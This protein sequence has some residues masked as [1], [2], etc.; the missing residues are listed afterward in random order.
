MND[1]DERELTG[2]INLFYKD[3]SNFLKERRKHI[4]SFI[5]IARKS[6]NLQFFTKWE[7]IKCKYS[8]ILEKGGSIDNFVAD[9]IYN[10]NETSLNSNVKHLPIRI[11]P[12]V[13]PNVYSERFYKLGMVKYIDGSTS[14]I[15]NYIEYFCQAIE[16]FGE[17]AG[18]TDNNTQNHIF[19]NDTKLFFD[20]FAN[21]FNNEDRIL[22]N[23]E[24]ILKNSVEY[25]TRVYFSSNYIPEWADGIHRMIENL[26]K[27]PYFVDK[28]DQ[29]MYLYKCAQYMRGNVY[30]DDALDAI[31]FCYQE[32]GNLQINNLNRLFGFKRIMYRSLSILENHNDIVLLDDFQ[33]RAIFDFLFSIRKE[34]LFVSL[35]NKLANEIDFDFEKI[36]HYYSICIKESDLNHAKIFWRIMKKADTHQLKAQYSTT[37]MSIVS[38]S[39]N[40]KIRDNLSI[41]DETTS[42]IEKICSVV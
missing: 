2:L 31:N 23:G 16:Q 17:K 8:K 6:D 3:T 18:S 28:H 33:S 41:A 22:L 14:T 1:S 29:V 34:G 15:K 35:F 7:E 4:D 10:I 40:E 36:H 26:I 5:N 20:F 39:I 30:I 42:I 37:V 21:G 25:L 32:A 19:L 38:N 11:I 9:L 13:I 27:N 24:L 12:F